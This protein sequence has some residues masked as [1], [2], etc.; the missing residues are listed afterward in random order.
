MVPIK[1]AMITIIIFV[2]INKLINT[3]KTFQKE[4]L[5]RSRL[6]SKGAIMPKS[7]NTFLIS[8]DKKG[9]II[10]FKLALYNYFHLH[11]NHSN[12]VTY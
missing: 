12:L 8:Q 6:L 2:N 11:N 4:P 5:T 3:L 7:I 1:I 10:Y 9:L